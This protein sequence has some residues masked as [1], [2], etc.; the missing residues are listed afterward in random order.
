MCMCQTNVI[1]TKAEY[2]RLVKQRDHARK[3]VVEVKTKLIVYRD[4]VINH[5]P[6]EHNVKEVS[7]INNCDEFKKQILQ[8][9]NYNAG[10]IV[11]N[12][13]TSKKLKKVRLRLRPNT[14]K[15]VLIYMMGTYLVYRTID[16]FYNF[17]DR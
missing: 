14:Y 16:D 15:S 7:V 10:L 3:E 9:K 13:H 6:A 4:S 1:L 11:T 17:Y 2:E 12:T 5:K 8:L